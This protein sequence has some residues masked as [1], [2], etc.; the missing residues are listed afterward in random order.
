MENN[1]TKHISMQRFIWEEKHF[2]RKMI[3]KHGKLYKHIWRQENM[4]DDSSPLNQSNR[5][6]LSFKHINLNMD[7]HTRG[8]WFIRDTKHRK[9]KPQILLQI[10]LSLECKSDTEVNR[11]KPTQLFEKNVHRQ[12]HT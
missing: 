10:I 11:I 4:V 2:A 1:D 5:D 6:Q 7:H 12:T 8:K 9:A 3:K